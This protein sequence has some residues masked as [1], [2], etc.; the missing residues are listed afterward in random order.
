MC[1]WHQ[2]SESSC[3]DDGGAADKDWKATL[4]TQ[5]KGRDGWG[6]L[7]LF[8]ITAGKQRRLA[9]S[10]SWMQPSPAPRSALD[11]AH[12]SI[13][14]H[15]VSHTNPMRPFATLSYHSCVRTSWLPDYWSN[16]ACLSSLLAFWWLLKPNGD[17]H[18]GHCRPIERRC[19]FWLF[20]LLCLAI[21]KT[22]VEAKIVTF[23]KISALNWRWTR[24]AQLEG[25]RSS[26]NKAM[27]FY[28]NMI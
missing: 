19:H 11:H 10:R 18:W 7:E 1:R 20:I 4:N 16:H 26:S 5:P 22:W 9:D 12:L 3:T 24:M 17:H 28:E 15:L 14:Q 6:W 8:Q 2:V 13:P 23:F 21:S 27:H 25:F